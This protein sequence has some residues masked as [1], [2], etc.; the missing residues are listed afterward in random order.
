M[1]LLSIL[2][3]VMTIAFSLLILLLKIRKK[4]ESIKSKKQILTKEEISASELTNIIDI[5]DKFLYTKDQKIFTYLKISP[6]N[7][8]LFSLREKESLSSIISAELSRETKPFKLLALGRPV[9]ITPLIDKYEVLL[10]L[11]DDAKQKE[12]L[13]LEMDQMKAY[14][15]SEEVIERQFFIVLWEKYYMGCETEV[16]KRT[17]E[18]ALSFQAAHIRCEIIT[19]SAIIK[20]VNMIHNPAFI[21]LEDTEYTENIPT[22]KKKGSI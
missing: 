22:L 13:R 20:L 14:M 11:S 1:S 10:S 8:D 4:P 12:L 19:E 5:K 3:V 6:V 17:R 9:D 2:S 16:L 7:L 15:F 21:H 18:F